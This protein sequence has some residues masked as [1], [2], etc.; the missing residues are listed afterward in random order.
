MARVSVSR[1]GSFVTRPRI[2]AADL[3]G[4]PGLRRPPRDGL[5]ER[6]PE[7]VAEAL[8]IPD[9]GRRAT[10]HLLA[11]GLLTDPGGVQTG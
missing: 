1:N 11:L 3:K 8:A 9:V 10:K 2:T 5:L 6:Q 4:L 7:T